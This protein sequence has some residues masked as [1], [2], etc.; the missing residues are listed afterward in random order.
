LAPRVLRAATADD[1]AWRDVRR[2][3]DQLARAGPDQPRRRAAGGPTSAPPSPSPT[4]TGWRSA[5]A[6]APGHYKLANGRGARLDERDPLATEPWLVAAELD[7]AGR[8]RASA[9]PRRWTAASWRGL[10]ATA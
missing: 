6:G 9:R 5:A 2:V 10:S 4:P 8:R 7:D 3:R 1:P